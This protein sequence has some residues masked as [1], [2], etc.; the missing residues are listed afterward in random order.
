MASRLGTGKWQTF[1]YSVGT[2]NSWKTTE[3]NN[4]T[5]SWVAFSRV[6]H[7]ETREGWPLL[8]VETERNGDSRSTNERSPSLVGSLD[9]LCRY[10]RF[11]SWLLLSAQYKKIIFLFAVHYFTSFVPI[12]QQAE[13]IVVPGHLSLNG[14][15]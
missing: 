2:I 7:R 3:A 14:C 1:F 11:L 10:K 15:L 9:S 12:A 6:R 13:Q 4:F 5:G 8:T